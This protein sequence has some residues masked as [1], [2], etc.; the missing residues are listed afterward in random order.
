MFT[1]VACYLEEKGGQDT[2]SREKAKSLF[3]HHMVDN[4]ASPWQNE[5]E[6][7]LRWKKR[8]GKLKPS[9]PK[10]DFQTMK[11]LETLMTESSVY[12]RK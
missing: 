7:S 5:L 8:D 11:E 6:R 12:C 1:G 10:P 4:I 2:R 9:P 3:P